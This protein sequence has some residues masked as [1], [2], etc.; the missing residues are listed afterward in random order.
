MITRS[1]FLT[2]TTTTINILCCWPIC[3]CICYHRFLETCFYINNF[4]QTFHDKLAY[5]RKNIKTNTNCVSRNTF[6]GQH[7]CDMRKTFCNYNFL[8][9]YLWKAAQTLIVSYKIT[10][11]GRRK[12]PSKACETWYF[13][14]DLHSTEISPFC[15]HLHRT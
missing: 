1:I 4:L 3:I 10:H 9:V 2:R 11:I 5:K 13:C 15:R 14:R 6:F 7:E 8:S 12:I